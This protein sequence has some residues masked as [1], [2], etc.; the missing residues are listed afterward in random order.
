MLGG[1]H[2]DRLQ[3]GMAHSF[4]KVVGTAAQIK[5]GK[6]IFTAYV[7][8]DGIGLAKEALKTARPRMPGNYS[9][10]IEPISA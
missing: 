5:R 4:G 2:A 10:E 8:K 7:F 3:S 9:V 6:E 1:A